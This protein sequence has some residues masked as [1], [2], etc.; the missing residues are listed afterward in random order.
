MITKGYQSIHLAAQYLAAAGI[1]FIPEREDDS[2]TN[3]GY[4]IDDKSFETWPLNDSGSKLRFDLARYE[5]NWISRSESRSLTLD[6]CSHTQV[7]EWISATCSAYKLNNPYKYKFHYK[8]PYPISDDY[9]FKT[10]PEA[11]AREIRLRSLAHN[12]LSQFLLQHQLISDI[13]TWPHHFDTGIFFLLPSNK[14]ISIGMG[15]A[16]PD[17]VVDD[18]YFY[19][20]GYQGHESLDTT[21]FKALEHGK[22]INKGFTG[23]VLPATNQDKEVVFSFFSQAIE[24][25]L[26][27]Y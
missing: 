1:S 3:L 16:I 4:S 21:E 26:A 23:A 25:Y 14:E 9:V 18:Y 10:D 15:L 22:W 19:A 12:A 27:A 24:A 20:S 6:G 13:R 8:L 17:S 7:L 5:L 2:H 11:L